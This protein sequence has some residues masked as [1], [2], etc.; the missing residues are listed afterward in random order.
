MM[1]RSVPTGL[2]NVLARR[3]VN[4]AGTESHLVVVAIAMKL[5]ML[6]IHIAVEFGVR[7]EPVK[8]VVTVVQTEAVG[9]NS[10]G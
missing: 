10:G 9:P 3:L 6:L 2:S 4:L 5:K 1:V 7:C 8:R